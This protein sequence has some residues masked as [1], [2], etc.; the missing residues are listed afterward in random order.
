ML[1]NKENTTLV[2][3]KPLQEWI[4]FIF[5][6]SALF[7]FDLSS[8]ALQEVNSYSEETGVSSVSSELT[9]D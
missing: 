9:T 5:I 2:A 1:I 8:N 7:R 6:Y 3:S 4:T